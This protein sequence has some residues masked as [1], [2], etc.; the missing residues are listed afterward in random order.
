MA[1]DRNKI[2][3]DIRRKFQDKIKKTVLDKNIQ[4]LVDEYIEIQEYISENG[5]DVSDLPSKSD[6]KLWFQDLPESQ[7]FIHADGTTEPMFELDIDRI[8]LTDDL[9]LDVFKKFYDWGWIKGEDFPKTIKLLVKYCK[10]YLH[11][12]NNLNKKK[13]ETRLIN[14]F[15]VGII[16]YNHLERAPY[17]PKSYI[18]SGFQT[19]IAHLIILDKF[20]S[21]L[22]KD[23][24][25]E[26]DSFDL[27][28]CVDI[29]TM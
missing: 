1:I 16:R 12:K 14:I 23:S 6:I 9:A 4:G 24:D 29:D 22:L 2:A 10:V 28:D 19:F 25:K 7:E 27:F 15:L 20:D 3:L 8:C 5:H 21:G 11:T 18:N 26:F 17:L 13:I